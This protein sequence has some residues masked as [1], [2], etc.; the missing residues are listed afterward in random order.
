[1]AILNVPSSA[2]S[3]STNG[4]SYLY[5]LTP[6]QWQ[7]ATTQFA[8]ET[9]RDKM[10][11]LF[12]S[13]Y[14]VIRSFRVYPFDLST[15]A[16][17]IAGPWL[18]RLGFADL[19]AAVGNVGRIMDFSKV[20]DLGQTYV[21]EWSGSFL[22]FEPYTNV[23]IYLPYIGFV[24]LKAKDIV[25]CYVH[26]YYVVDY[27]TGTVKG[28]VVRQ[29]ISNPSTDDRIL[30]IGEGVIGLDIPILSNNAAS[31]ANQ[32][33]IAEKHAS[34][35]SAIIGATS[36]AATAA[37]LIAAI[38]GFATGNVGLGIKGTI[39]AVGATAAGTTSLVQTGVS[40][41]NTVAALESHFGAVGEPGGVSAW[42]APQRAILYRGHINV[43]EP[44]DYSEF[45]GRPL[46]KTRELNTMHGYTEISKIH[47][48]QFGSQTAS[49]NIPAPTSQE[50][51]E[52]E[53]L[54]RSG[55]IFS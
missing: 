13:P 4:R 14:E 3:P 33:R 11:Y 46:E 32:Q 7:L 2:N 38:A 55:V 6:Q 44:A 17:E 24:A 52:I 20:I 50:L 45:F 51:D 22:D 15:W 35:Q 41:A 26:V 48:Q 31:L 28:Y 40:R 30:A 25:N 16:T 42:Y 34:T 29:L 36:G 21:A 12:A 1:M 9:V 23:Q 18:F 27:A 43:E 54:L 10:K 47:L 49:N 39:A 19:T 37:G 5:V 53:T 8:D